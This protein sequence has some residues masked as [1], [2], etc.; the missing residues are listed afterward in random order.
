MIAAI[1]TA[2]VALQAFACILAI[3]FFA[4]YR[5]FAGLVVIVVLVSIT[6]RQGYCLVRFLSLPASA[7]YSPQYEIMGLLVSSVL[8]LG[9]VW[10]RNVLHEL[11]Q[12][13]RELDAHRREL[14]RRVR[15]HDCLLALD[16]LA[17]N[18]RLNA[19]ELLIRAVRAIAD[20]IPLNLSMQLRILLGDR[21]YA[22][23]AREDLFPAL[24]TDV[25][26]RGRTVGR[27]EVRL[28]RAGELSGGLAQDELSTLLGL[29][30]V[31]LGEVIGRKW[32]EEEA[33]CR[34]EYLIKADKMEALAILVSGVTHEINNPN[35]AIQLGAD[36]I[37]KVWEEVKP[38]LDEAAAREGDFQVGGMRYG[39][40]RDFLPSLL[41]TIRESSRRIKSIMQ[42]LRD[43][44]R[45]A[46]ETPDE[47]LDINTVV[48]VAISLLTNLLRR[49]TDRFSVDYAAR[50][51]YIKGNHRRLEQV[52]IRLLQNACQRLPD[53]Q[54]AMTIATGYDESRQRVTV[55][56][57]DE[58]RSLAPEII[59]HAHET[60]GPPFRLPDSAGLSMFIAASIVHEHGGFMDVASEPD[61]GTTVTLTFPLCH[62]VCSPPA[63]LEEHPIP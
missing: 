26:V 18:Q 61:G 40:V 13:R 44:A 51:P 5:R 29:V 59:E 23:D 45:H 39:E 62:P 46:P 6:A 11:E 49:S 8:V 55:R 25:V 16:R 33:S 53:R 48:A 35:F 63:T 50:L 57:H 30:A 28:T 41:D 31:R 15:E 34:R 47:E 38:V 42:E 27:I 54:A 36:T 32:N 3:L 20:A 58:G 19:D 60:V 2:S 24:T 12:S 52:M 7:A 43:F 4:K 10:A 17:E 21:W 14:E 37:G 56:L 1:M 9:F 22:S